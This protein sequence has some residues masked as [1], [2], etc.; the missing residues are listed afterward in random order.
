MMFTTAF[1]ENRAPFL[2]NR[3]LQTLL[4]LFVIFWLYTGFT[5]PAIKN[6]MLENTLTV[7]AVV[8]VVVFYRYY[9]LSDL[10]YTLIFLFMM[11]HVY[12]S[13]YEYSENP[14]GF[15][16][17]DKLNLERNHYD[18]IVHVSF[19][20]L[21]AYPMFELFRN[22]T[23]LP[24]WATFILPVEITISLSAIY[25]L[26][27]WLVAD[28]FFPEQGAA[29]LGLQGDVWDAQKDIALAL[30][31]ASVAMAVTFVHFINNAKQKKQQKN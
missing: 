18:R 30:A 15:W 7:S 11:L 14:F 16:L 25:E 2:K 31:G 26:V 12:G 3:L 21:L 17:Q 27:E 6:W 19:G 8:L 4:L 24:A 9:Q 5:T 28:L 20:L 22:N 23:N 10:S 29:Y 1:T 13:Q